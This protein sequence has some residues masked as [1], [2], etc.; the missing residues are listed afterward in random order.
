MDS[1][2]YL[3]SIIMKKM[4]QQKCEWIGW[5]HVHLPS[6]IACGSTIADSKVLS[7]ESYLKY[8]IYKTFL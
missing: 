3:Q 7:G 6:W 8:N 1:S 5:F 4:F 2:N